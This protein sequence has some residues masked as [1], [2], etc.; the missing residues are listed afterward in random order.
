MNTFELRV[1]NYFPDGWDSTH[2]GVT[3]NEPTEIVNDV[4]L[5][6]EQLD[7][8]YGDPEHN[9]G[10][11]L[12][13]TRYIEVVGKV[14]GVDFDK[15]GIKING[16]TAG[17]DENP[18]AIINMD[19]V[20]GGFVEVVED[21]TRFKSAITFADKVDGQWTLR[22]R[23]EAKIDYLF[24]LDGELV[25]EGDG[26]S[27]PK[28]EFEI[29]DTGG[30]EPDPVFYTI[31]FDFNDGTDAK[32]DV[33]V[34]EG[35]MVEKLGVSEREG[36]KFLGWFEGKKRFDFDTLIVE[37]II[38]VAK[39]KE[40]AAKPIKHTVTF[41][42]DDD[43]TKDVEVKVEHGE[44]V[45]EQAASIRDGYTFKGWYLEGEEFD[46]NSPIIENITLVAEW[47]EIFH[48]VI[49][50]FGDGETE[51]MEVMVRHGATMTKLEPERENYD[52]LGWFKDDVKFN[53]ETP[54]T[55]EMTLIAKWNIFAYEVK[56]SSIG[57][58]TVS[59]MVD[60]I[61]VANGALVEHGKDIVFTA[62]PNSLSV[63]RDWML[64]GERLGRND[65]AYTL[66]ELN[67]TVNLTVMF[68]ARKVAVP[69]SR[70]SKQAQDLKSLR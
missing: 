65:F 35:E 12:A 32:T 13:L 7:N 27:L 44:L 15:I 29:T 3:R 38:L 20:G 64:N 50:V 52:F 46:F 16:E 5:T 24:F 53:F 26:G 18:L 57:G 9:D 6:E 58:G 2:E 59:A 61:S 22:P 1:F 10:R 43:Y 19:S 25:A 47:M 21:D 66:E 28:I 34:E 48:T 23:S 30:G 45:A 69:P 42:F 17:G 70:F 67:G 33:Q 8:W 55:K 4:V 60:G 62:R 68:E 14:L 41:V 56:F 40:L 31:T 51:D 11:G 36:F 63:I 54:I 39:W 49:F 37:N